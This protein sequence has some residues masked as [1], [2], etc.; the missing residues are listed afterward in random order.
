MKWV[1]F[2]GQRNLITFYK[3]Q[4]LGG[5]NYNSE[6]EICSV[7]KIKHSYKKWINPKHWKNDT[8]LSPKVEATTLSWSKLGDMVKAKSQSTHSPTLSLLKMERNKD[9]TFCYL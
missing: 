2:T 7:K 4:Y 9:I 5:T 8:K 6:E 1:T 3:Y